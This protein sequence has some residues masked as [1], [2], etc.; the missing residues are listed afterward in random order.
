MRNKIFR[1]LRF[2]L[3]FFF[4][5]KKRNESGEENF[6][7]ILSLYLVKKISKRP[8]FLINPSRFLFRNLIPHYFAIGSIISRSNKK[9]II[10]GSGIIRENENIKG[11]TFLAVRGPK[12]RDRIL[13]LG[14]KCEE[15]YGDPGILAPLFYNPT[16]NKETDVIGVI[17][18]YVDY[19]SV[20]ELYKD[21]PQYKVINLL[22]NNIE[23][24]IYEVLTC[25]KILS[26]SLHG[27]I[28]SHVYNIPALWIKFSDRLVGDD[29]KFYDYF[30]SVSL[31]YKKVFNYED[32]MD[33]EILFSD[34]KDIVLPKAELIA[35]RQEKLLAV[36]PF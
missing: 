7:D 36:C 11:G 18:H 8:V 25:S 21:R 12:T 9:S 29:I 28:I 22:N 10:W 3:F 17:P 27:V 32:S 33:V 4:Y 35:D 6:G 23:T 20:C 15:V 30:E 34:N 2:P 5:S 16:K 31:H 24:V 19:D 14:F 1:L 26:S 13:A